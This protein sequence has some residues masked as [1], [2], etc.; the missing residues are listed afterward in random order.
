MKVFG[1]KYIVVIFGIFNIGVGYFNLGISIIVD[2]VL[3]GREK[4]DDYDSGLDLLMYV[5]AIFLLI[6]LLLM[7]LENEKPIFP[8][9]DD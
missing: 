6:S 9:I 5:S 3:S 7:T 1:M 8:N 4:G 2:Y